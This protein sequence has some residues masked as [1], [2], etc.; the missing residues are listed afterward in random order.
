MKVTYTD[1]NG[2]KQTTS[3]ADALKPH[4]DTYDH[5][6]V[7]AAHAEA[8]KGLEIVGNMLA[9]MVE[10]KVLTFEEALEISG[11]T[12]SLRDATLVP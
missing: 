3:L 7:E 8:T 5:G 2:R 9:A 1:Y 6:R 11:Q 4:V 12:Y 10:K